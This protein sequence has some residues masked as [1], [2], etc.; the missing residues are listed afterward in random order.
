MLIKKLPK[1][2]INV[3]A[4][5][6]VVERPYSVVKELVENS[7]DAQANEI[8][9]DVSK[10]WRSLIVVKDNGQGI[11][12]EDLPL[13]IQEF[14]TSKISKID[15]LYNLYTFWFRWEALSSISSVSHF[16]IISK[17]SESDIGWKLEKLDN[18]IDISPVNVNISHWTQVYVENL[19][20]NLPVRRKFLKSEQTEFKYIQDL[21]TNYSIKYFDKTFK[22]IHNWKEIFSYEKTDS[23]FSRLQ[24]IFP[25]NWAENYL[26]FEFKN[27]QISLYGFMGKSILKFNSSMIKI[28]VNWR[29]IK[30]KIIQ[31]AI[32]QAYSRWIEPGMYPFVILFLDIKP[33]LVDVNVHP[34]KEEVKF[35]DPWNIYN[36]VF[37]V[38]KS[39]LESDKWIEEKASYVPLDKVTSKNFLKSQNKTANNTF[40]KAL[41]LNFSTNI[42]DNTNK[43]VSNWLD[44]NV[45]W[46][47]FDSYILFT[48][49]E[50]FYIIDQHA[51]AERIIFEKM[52]LEYNSEDIVLLSVPMTFEIKWDVSE[53]LNKLNQ[54]WFDISKF[55]E[56]KVILYSVPK[57]LEK[58]KIDIAGLVNSLLNSEIEDISINKVLEQVLATK[59]CKAAIKA[60]H[61][62]SFEEMKQL[63]QD[64]E[65]YIN[66]FFVCQHGRP[67][68]IKLKKEDIDKLFDRK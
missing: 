54:I 2:L 46:Q 20:Y 9:V 14:A 40:D 36:I 67:S 65:K 42:L 16:K 62:L 61:K 48:K 23:L 63:I 10:W 52:R 8:V 28:F 47:I 59:S 5:G 66:W 26:N 30:D 44:I 4:A 29:V 24:Q 1:N 49:G 57:V 41:D 17:V 33:E 35:S 25:K 21:L 53:K 68:V 27:D 34:R 56:N 12:K 31:K 45:I 32:M 15:D 64:G 60:N 3:L 13:T 22:L 43:Q 51:V 38:L 11:S 55:G 18:K 58:Y 7:L 19:F 37:N 6:E 39:K 50:D